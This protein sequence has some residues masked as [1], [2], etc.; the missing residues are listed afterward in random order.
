[1]GRPLTA[2]LRRLEE[3]ATLAL[4]G[5]ALA[6][7]ALLPLLFLIGGVLRAPQEMSAG[8]AVLRSAEPWRLLLRSVSSALCVA[9]LCIAIGVPLGLVLGRTDVRGR[10][11]AL[12]LHAFP[13]F[14]PPF[15]LVLG[16]FQLP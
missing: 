2:R 10:W 12:L 5:V 8:L 14:L 7:A 16:W 1:M 6:L 15:L 4:A 13:A 11:A 9:A 3:P